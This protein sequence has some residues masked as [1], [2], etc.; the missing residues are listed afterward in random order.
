MPVIT[1]RVAV[2]VGAGHVS[3]VYPDAQSIGRVALQAEDVGA[4]LAGEGD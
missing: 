3:L 1:T 4:R 2:A